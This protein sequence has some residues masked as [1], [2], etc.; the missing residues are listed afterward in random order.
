LAS[1]LAEGTISA[2]N[3]ASR[4]N[5]LP[6]GLVAISIVTVLYPSITEFAVKGE[7]ERIG[8]AVGRGLQLLAFI[9]IPSTFGLSL[10]RVPIVRLAFERGAFSPED[11]LLTA[12][13]L[14]FYSLGLVWISWRELLNRTF[15]AFQDTATAMKIGVV[16]MV[17]NIGFNLALIRPLGYRGLALGTSLAAFTAVC[18]L[19]YRLNSAVR[20]FHM[21][22][23][24][25]GLLK[26][27]VSSGL[28]AGAVWWVRDALFLPQGL[29]NQT[30]T[31]IVGRG[32]LFDAAGLLL[33]VATG[34]AVYGVS[35]W[36]LN[37]ETLY[38]LLDTA[39]GVGERC[40]RISLTKGLG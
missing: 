39:R 28:M 22:S 9:M 36:M 12:N 8:A 34:L 25:L 24:L 10:L 11:T 37:I 20:T 16:S 19:L 33:C 18:L 3:Y 2:L 5:W 7:E 38:D 17:A 1:S 21:G 35:A 14:L 40:L 27:F 6:Y 23:L 31:R 13:A 26:I 29:L 4:L 32:A 15:F 30:V